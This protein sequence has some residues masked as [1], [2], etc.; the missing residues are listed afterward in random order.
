MNPTQQK[1]NDVTYLMREF[2]IELSNMIA[3]VSRLEKTKD[4]LSKHYEELDW[5]EKELVHN[6]IEDERKEKEY[7]RDAEEYQ[8]QNLLKRRSDE[9]VNFNN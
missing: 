2:I 3:C 5:E 7:Q 1:I 8:R 4:K 6:F 9:N